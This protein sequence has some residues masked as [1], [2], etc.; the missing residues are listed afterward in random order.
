M[1]SPDMAYLRMEIRLTVGRPWGL[2]GQIFVLTMARLII[3]VQGG[4]VDWTSPTNQMVGV[5]S[6]L[7]NRHLLALGIS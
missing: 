6:G 7:G 1:A 2:H 5:S 4:T 3:M